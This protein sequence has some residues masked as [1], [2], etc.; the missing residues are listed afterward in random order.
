MKKCLVLW[1]IA[2]SCISFGMEKKS[3]ISSKLRRKVTYDVMNGPMNNYSKLQRDTL[4]KFT[5]TTQ[6]N[7]NDDTMSV[8]FNPSFRKPK[9]FGEYALHYCKAIDA[10]TSVLLKLCKKGTYSH[11]DYDFFGTTAKITPQFE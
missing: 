1:C 6:L 8:I 11:L 10:I 5:V 3:I 2:Y 7:E 4:F 9:T